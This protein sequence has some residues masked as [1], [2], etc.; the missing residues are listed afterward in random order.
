MT[1]AHT[2][3]DM[4]TVIVSGIG[5]SVVE[6]ANFLSESF[7]WNYTMQLQHVNNCE[8]RA[9]LEYT[10]SEANETRSAV[11]VVNERGFYTSLICESLSDSGQAGGSGA[12]LGHWRRSVS[13]RGSGG[14]DGA[15]PLRRWTDIPVKN[16]KQSPNTLINKACWKLFLNLSFY[17]G[18]CQQV[19]IAHWYH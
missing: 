6:E 14:R 13:F 5:L 19:N 9:L 11:V 15:N 8:T 2:H 10:H 1:P 3:W 18:Q 16:L 12:R 4:L 7:C 17:I